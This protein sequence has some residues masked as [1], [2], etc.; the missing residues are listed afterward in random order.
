MTSGFLAL[1]RPTGPWRPGP[2][3]RARDRVDRICH[4]DTLFAAVTSAMVQLGK[5]EDWLAA[6][7]AAEV[8]LSSAFPFQGK[9]LFAPPPR[10]LWPPAPSTRVRWKGATLVPLSVIADLLAEKPLDENRWRV[11]GASECLVPQ[12]RPGPGP[13]RVAFRSAAAVDR[14]TGNVEPHITAC[15]EFTANAGMWLAV[16]FSDDDARLR[17]EEAVKG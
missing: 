17:W 9:T 16:S 14:L 6:A 12:D 5:L 10:S 4:S 11:D 3:S 13:N 1:L 8:R 15:L 7:N 2:H